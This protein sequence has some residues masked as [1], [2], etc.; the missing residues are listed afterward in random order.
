MAGSA[1]L[2]KHK[3]NTEY[4]QHNIL[5]RDAL[6][7]GTDSQLHPERVATRNPL[8]R[9]EPN[10]NRAR[11]REGV[12]ILS[13]K[14]Q[15]PPATAPI[16]NFIRRASQRPDPP[17]PD[18]NK[19]QGSTEGIKYINNTTMTRKSKQPGGHNPLTAHEVKRLKSSGWGTQSTRLSTAS[20]LPFGRCCLGLS[21]ISDGDA[22]ATPSGHVYSREAIL[23]YLLTKNGELRNQR[24][25]YDRRR[26]SVENRR[27]EWEERMMKSRRDEFAK[28]DQGAMSSTKTE[29]VVRIDAQGDVP[30]RG[31]AAASSVV[32]TTTVGKGRAENSLAHV[33][34]WLAS[35]QPRLG[36][37]GDDDG[38]DFDYAREIASLPPPPPDR[39]SSP[40]SGEPLR[41]KQLITLNLVHETSSAGASRG[42]GNDGGGDRV[43]CA[44]SHKAITTQCVVAIKNTGQVMLKSVYGELAYPT[45]TC[46][47]TGKKFK[48]KDVLELVRGRSGYAASGEV[49]ATKYNPTL[50]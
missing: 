23:N 10:K 17:R 12:N 14:S 29:L 5:Q 44:V 26:L 9:P 2:P 22:V 24:E 3:K 15:T 31:Y 33:S 36:G 38:S 46:P 25:E 30:A 34:Y 13:N 7:D 47:V 43:V 18:R 19:K 37:K 1:P 11:S 32:G 48:E 39:P 49:M 45:M 4:N 42:G 8:P 27:V 50:T 21:P 40:M 6:G 16:H 28:K 20:H 41:L 35:S